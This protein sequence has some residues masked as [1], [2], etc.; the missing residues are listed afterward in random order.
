MN[1]RKIQTKINKYKK[2]LKETE[3]SK[4]RIIEMIAEFPADNTPHNVH[5]FTHCYTEIAY[6][7][8][9]KIEFYERVLNER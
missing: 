9:V 6:D 2:A 8:I 1:R 4:K 3:K 5:L 7:L